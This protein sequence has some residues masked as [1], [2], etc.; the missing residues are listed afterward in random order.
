MAWGFGFFSGS[1]PVIV[2]FTIVINIP[3]AFI[4]SM[5]LLF[6]RPFRSLMSLLFISIFGG[7]LAFFWGQYISP[8]NDGLGY[9]E[10]ISE[11]WLTTPFASAFVLGAISSLVMAFWVLPKR[12][13]VSDRK[14]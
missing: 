4:I 7:F 2:F 13:E 12:S 5:V 11:N 3:P 6:F 9:W 14:Q 1:L 10:A 8:A